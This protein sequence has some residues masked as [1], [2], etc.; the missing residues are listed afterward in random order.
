MAQTP[1]TDR[2][3]TAPLGIADSC[4]RAL[5]IFVAGMALLLA[6]DLA[7]E[8]RGPTGEDRAIER[9]LASGNQALSTVIGTPAMVGVEEE[10][11]DADRRER[12]Q[13]TA[14]FLEQANLA[15]R[16]GEQASAVQVEA[17]RG[18]AAALA[19]LGKLWMLGWLLLPFGALAARLSCPH[20]AERDSRWTLVFGASALGGSAGLVALGLGAYGLGAPA[21]AVLAPLVSAIVVLNAWLLADHAKLDRAATLLRLVPLLVM[22]T[23][24]LMLAR[25]ILVGLAILA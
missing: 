7:S 5:A 11:E 22:L 17:E 4:W 10:E 12:A 19:F 16:R 14:F 9:A 3:R 24:G 18:G 6:I 21:P 23:V 8:P 13:A 20:M 25:E 2:E 1:S 15:W